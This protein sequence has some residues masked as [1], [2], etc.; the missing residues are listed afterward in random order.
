MLSA[1]TIVFTEDTDGLALPG[2]KPLLCRRAAWCAGRMMTGAKI[3]L[4]TEM[5][6]ARD[7]LADLA[8]VSWMMSLPQRQAAYAAHPAG[9]G[10]P[11]LRADGGAGLVAVMFGDIAAPAPDHIVLP[12][13]WEPAEPG[14]EFTVQLHGTITLAPAAEP[15]HSAL[16]LTGVCPVPPSA[17]T[18]HGREQVRLEFTEA[19]REFITSVARDI[20]RAAGPGP[21]PDLLGP[22]WAW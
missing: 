10:R 18:P 14:D 7:G 20:T 3:V 4:N 15:G 19:A 1:R 5:D 16:T 11:G 2:P 9:R 13:R 6:A 17:L 21:D 22:S 12:V 8:G